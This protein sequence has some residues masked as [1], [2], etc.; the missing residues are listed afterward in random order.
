MRESNTFSPE[1]TTD[2]T[3][4]EFFAGIGLM[5]LGLEKAG[6][7]TVWANDIDEDK[8]AMYRHHFNDA[9]CH[10]VREDVHA[11]PTGSIPPVG[12]ATASFPCTDLSLAGAVMIDAS[13]FVPQSRQRLLNIALPRWDCPNLHW[14]EK[15]TRLWKAG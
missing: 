2:K 7:K 12:L 11:L 3:V 15:G 6:W 1:M 14:S 8:E 10:F 5:R 4:A 13:H 9:D